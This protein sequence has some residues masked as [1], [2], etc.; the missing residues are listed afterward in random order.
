METCLVKIKLHII[1]INVKALTFV[2]IYFIEV[3]NPLS[4]TQED[5]KETKCCNQIFLMAPL[6]NIYNL[7][8]LN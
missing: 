4:R 8:I 6:C 1:N 7:N 2:S 3:H 5:E